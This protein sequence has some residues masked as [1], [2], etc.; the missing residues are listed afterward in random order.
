VPTALETG[1]VLADARPANNDEHHP[2]T[3]THDSRLNISCKEHM[4]DTTQLTGLNRSS[5]STA[6]PCSSVVRLVL[7][8]TYPILLA[9]MEHLFA[10][11]PGFRVLTCCTD[12]DEVIRAVGSHRPDVLVLDLEI[13]G[14]ARKVL[15]ALAASTPATRIVIV[16]ARLDEQDVLEMTQL[17]ATGMLLKSMPRHSLLQCVRKVH[18]GATWLEKV[19][20]S[21]AVEQLLRHETGRRDALEKL[22]P[23]ELEIVL[24]AAGGDSNKA[25]AD[26]LSISEGTIKGHFHHIYEKCG[27]KNRLELILHARDRGWF[28]V[29]SAAAE[30]ARSAT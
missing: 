18:R 8:D 28:S 20:M 15:R 2:V 9:G 29:W 4:E 17:G 24:L 14:S 3:H 30:A 10:S 13:P 25:I 6:L 7:A 5:A 23:R 21:R 22:S 19:S 26:R 12:A 11:E 1:G 27:V 16:A